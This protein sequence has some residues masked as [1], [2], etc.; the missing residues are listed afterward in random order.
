MLKHFACCL[1]WGL[2]N[3]SICLLGQCL[4]KLKQSFIKKKCLGKLYPIA[5]HQLSVPAHFC[6]QTRAILWVFM[7]EI[8][9]HPPYCPDL[10]TLIFCLLTGFFLKEQYFFFSVKIPRTSSCLEKW[11]LSTLKSDLSWWSLCWQIIFMF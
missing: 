3:D 2:N 9:R 11:L 8:I 5:L 6:H 10:A 4:E 7:Q 1:S